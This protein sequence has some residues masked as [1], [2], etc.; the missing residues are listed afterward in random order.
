MNKKAEFKNFITIMAKTFVNNFKGFDNCR[1]RNEEFTNDNGVKGRIIILT[2]DDD[3]GEKDDFAY[4]FVFPRGDHCYYVDCIEID[5]C[6]KYVIYEIFNTI[7]LSEPKTI[8]N[9]IK[10]DL[11]DKVDESELYVYDHI[12][13]KKGSDKKFTGIKV[14]KYSNGNRRYE[15]SFANGFLHGKVESWGKNGEKL[16]VGFYNHGKVEGRFENWFL[17]GNLDTVT[18]YLY[19]KQNGKQEDWYKNK[20]KKYEIYLIKG[21]AEGKQE[22]WFE[23]GNKKYIEHWIN[24]RLNGTREFWFESSEK[25]KNEIYKMGLPISSTH[26]SKNGVYELKFTFDEK[27]ELLS[28]ELFESNKK[29]AFKLKDIP[30][31]LNDPHL[32]PGDSQ[33]KK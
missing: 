30:I 1:S 5:Y 16:Q 18:N 19:D 24:G 27:G 22:G 17:N 23:N 9:E 4:T 2:M 25:R 32:L 12:T 21:R 14:K 31:L 33:I 6:E 3:L 8:K 29:I 26:W 13:F 15:H 11:L 20:I 10:P 28:R 7:K